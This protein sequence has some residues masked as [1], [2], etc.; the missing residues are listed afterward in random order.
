MVINGILNSTNSYK[1]NIDE[2]VFLKNLDSHRLNVI[3]IVLNVAHP[4]LNLIIGYVIL[5]SMT[6]SGDHCRLY[7]VS[8]GVLILVSYTILI[9]T[10]YVLKINNLSLGGI[11][12]AEFVRSPIVTIVLIILCYTLTINLKR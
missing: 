7:L 12:M 11:T 8:Y 4:I 6:R 10:H 2:I 3:K 1:A 5:K 9:I